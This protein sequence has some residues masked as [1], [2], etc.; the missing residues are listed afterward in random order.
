MPRLDVAA[1]GEKEST[2]LDNVA[3][4]DRKTQSLNNTLIKYINED[5]KWKAD[6]ADLLTRHENGS[7]DA[8]D[9]AG[10]LANIT[11]EFRS[12]KIMENIVEQLC[13]REMTDR[14]DMV[15]KAHT[16]T[17]DWIFDPPK[18]QRYQWSSFSDW[19]NGKDPL[20][21]ITGKAGSGKSTLMKYLLK[22]SRTTK[23]LTKCAGS[24][25]LY[26]SD[27]FFW[28]S[29]TP[30]QM[31]SQGLLRTLILQVVKKRR[32]LIP[33]LF[34]KRWHYYKHYGADLHPWDLQELQ[35]AFRALLKEDGKSI[36]VCFFIDGLDEFS[37]DH[38]ALVNMIKGFVSQSAK[39]CISSRPWVCFDDA[40][41]HDPHLLLERLTRPDIIAYITSEFQSNRRYLEL[42]EEEPKYTKQLVD[43]IA[44][45]AAGV[46]LWVILVVRSL[47]EGFSNADRSTDLRKRLDA[48]PTDLEALFSKM[49]DSV[50]PLYRGHA[51]QLFQLVRASI[52]PLT[53]LRISFA[54]EEDPDYAIKAEV[55]PLTVNQIAR[56][57]DV[58]NRR[59]KSR[60]MGM[61]E[62][63]Q[64][65]TIDASDGSLS[66]PQTTGI[67]LPSSEIG[68]N[69]T[70]QYLHRTVK[71]FFRQPSTWERIVSMSPTTYYPNL[72]LF[73][74]CLLHLKTYTEDHSFIFGST[75]GLALRYARK[76]EIKTGIS[77]VELLDKLDST[78]NLICTQKGFL[79]QRINQ[80]DKNWT[81]IC[82]FMPIE[83]ESGSNFLSLAV[84]S[85]LRLYVQQKI[86]GRQL[87]LSTN[88]FNS[89]LVYALSPS[90]IPQ[91][92]WPPIHMIRILINEGLRR[93]NF[94]SS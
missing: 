37:G 83:L 23:H 31:S 66:L 48:L 77:P 27:F 5:K 75:V 7:S 52:E 51:S 20:Y 63:P 35:N 41:G 46:F 29:G 10:G 90:P 82:G 36:K 81:A 25:P 68:R 9:F 84:M 33:S 94:S 45:K 61:L 69:K 13:F 58:M 4:V 42:E 43:E 15:A 62:V 2:L 12:E 26:V 78:L 57:Q 72:A 6:I 80:S 17:F 85:D 93:G 40:F 91:G 65:D 49:L 87:K 18:N 60:C 88:D 71:D 76:A 1:S 59:L 11:E 70:I 32:S 86:V 19:L 92:A 56:R 21:W 54:D 53:L 24:L 3:H 22:D 50:D 73:G 74:S 30:I 44:D 16:K 64:V 28:N 34:P 38:V 14:E 79:A 67:G 89:L 8:G 55:K 39:F 47:L